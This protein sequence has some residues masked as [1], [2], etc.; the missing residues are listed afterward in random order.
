[1]ILLFMNL[2]ETENKKSKRDSLFQLLSKGH[3]DPVLLYLSVEKVKNK[4]VSN[5]LIWSFS[6]QKVPLQIR[7]KS[8]K[9]T[10]TA[11]TKEENF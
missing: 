11:Q 6:K 9:R 2:L 3:K 4:Q 1:M 10:K 7:T 8:M 5:S